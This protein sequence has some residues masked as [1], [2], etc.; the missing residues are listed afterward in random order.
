MELKIGPL[1]VPVIFG[2]LKEPDT[3]GFYS[4]YP[5]PTININN[6]LEPKIKAMTLL[7]EVLECLTDIYGWKMSEGDIRSLE[8]ALSM[9]VLENVEEIRGW[10]HDLQDAEHFDIKI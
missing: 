4:P 3:F 6:N 2:P 1:S 8:C 10:L 9:M 5:K 7:H